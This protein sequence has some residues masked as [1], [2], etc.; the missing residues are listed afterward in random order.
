MTD[1]KPK[2]PHCNA[3]LLKLRNPIGSTWGEG[4][5]WVCFND[6]C[7]YYVRGWTWMQEKFNKKASYRHRFNPQNGETGPLPTWSPDAH[8][9][10]IITD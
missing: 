9:D 10:R 7:S 3:D 4:F 2:C 5:Q 6:E 1:E 8:K